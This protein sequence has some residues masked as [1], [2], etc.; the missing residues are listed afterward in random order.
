[1]KRAEKN[2]IQLQIKELIS[3]IHIRRKSYKDAEKILLEM[4]YEYN[5]LEIGYLNLSDMYFYTKELDKGLDIINKGI[6]KFPDY[7][8]FYKNLAAIYKNKGQFN[9]AIECHL[10]ILKKIN[11]I[12]LVIM[13]YQLF[14]TL[15]SIKMILID[16]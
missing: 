13:N 4:V 1:M 9:K 10:L 6:S 15:R 16:Y 7:I 11:L 8:P 12:F 2:N 3:R 14:M 5:H